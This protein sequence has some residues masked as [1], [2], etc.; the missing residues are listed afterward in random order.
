MSE[1]NP[2][3]KQTTVSIGLAALVWLSFWPVGL[4]GGFARTATRAEWTHPKAQQLVTDRDG[5]FVLLEDSRLMTVEG[6]EAHFSGDE[7]R[8]WSSKG[9]VLRERDPRIHREWRV[10]H[11]TRK[12][13]I[14]LVFLD[15]KPRKWGWNNQTNEPEPDVFNEVWSVRSAD[16]GES[17]TD[18]RL[19][20]REY[21]GAMV[22][23]LETSSGRVVVP[24]M[25][26]LRRPGRHA[27]VTYFSDD[28]GR[29][30]SQSNL[31][32]LGG[33]GHHDGA[34][35]PT[36][37]ELRDGRLWTLIR[38]NWD[39][40]WEAFSQDEGR[41][42]RVIRPSSVDASSAPG[43]LIRL[44]GGRLVL[45]WNRLHPEGM[46]LQEWN[47]RPGARREFPYSR[48]PGSSQREELSI[49]FSE[50]DGKTWTRPQVVARQ[51]GGWLSY[52]Y[53]F[54]RRPGE[55]WLTT[56][57]AGIRA[58]GKREVI[59]GVRLRLMESDFAGE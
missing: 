49:A 47:R 15:T 2:V 28:E 35:E 9:P 10:L 44:S 18:A 40:F 45:A 30:W 6:N 34:I 37:V 36:L 17:W 46:T 29:T 55:I 14:V 19:L 1:P 48:I 23:I 22:D 24:V 31:I 50:D 53:L 39:R 7:G 32:D 27:F 4:S 12:G 52:P 54:E 42:W 20:S 59:A 51:P 5:P 56:H 13:A 21:C 57:Y 16:D 26:I 58:G 43:H 8:T 11:K 25:K 41:S 33:H 38:T 3:R